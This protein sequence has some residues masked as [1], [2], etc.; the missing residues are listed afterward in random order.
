MDCPVRT[1]QKSEGI[2]LLVT[3]VPSL[4]ALLDH[5]V[6]EIAAQPVIQLL[7]PAS[8]E[9]PIAQCMKASRQGWDAMWGRK[10]PT[11]PATDSDMIQIEHCIFAGRGISHPI[12]LGP[13]M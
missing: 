12:L 13:E 3:Y 7:V 6:F 1:E 9:R 5:F 4:G 10:K 8:V 2:T 11:A